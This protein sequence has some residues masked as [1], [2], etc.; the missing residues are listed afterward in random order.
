MTVIYPCEV[1]TFTTAQY[2]PAQKSMELIP[3]SKASTRYCLK[4]YRKLRN[5]R[6]SSSSVTSMQQHILQSFDAFLTVKRLS[7]TLIATITETDWNRSVDHTNYLSRI[8]FSNIAC[9][10]DTHGI[11]MIEKL[12]KLL[13]IYWLKNTF[14]NIWRTLEYT[15][16]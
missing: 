10:T 6:N 8:R 2:A 1:T 16:V 13:I 3:E 4:P 7:L 12:E 11:V 15:V 9:F 5:I 14:S